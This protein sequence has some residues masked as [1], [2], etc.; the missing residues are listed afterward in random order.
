L[1][2]VGLLA[3][4]APIGLFFATGAMV[5]RDEYLGGAISALVGGAG[6]GALGDGF[7]NVAFQYLFATLAGLLVLAVIVLPLAAKLM[8]KTPLVRLLQS[9]GS[10]MAA[11]LG[12]SS[13]LAVLPLTYG[14]VSEIAKVDDRASAMVLPLGPLFNVGATVIC[15]VV[16]LLTMARFTGIELTVFQYVLVALVPIFL[17][18]G[19]A[20]FPYPL[21]GIVTAGVAIIGMPAGIMGAFFGVLLADWLVDRVRSAVNVWSDTVGTA[22]IAESFEFK[23]AR[24]VRGEPR[25]R[26]TRTPRKR[27]ERQPRDRRRPDSRAPRDTRPQRRRTDSRGSDRK[28]WESRDGSRSTTRST[29]RD[30]RDTTSPTP[31]TRQEEKSPF[32]MSPKHSLEHE[33]DTTPKA[34]LSN[35]G[36]TK[37]ASGPTR[38][39]RQSSES[40]SGRQHR[41]TERSAPA[42][43]STPSET[44]K[45]EASPK[46]TEVSEPV[47]AQEQEATE[48][49]RLSPE[50]IARELKKV[51]TQL[52]TYSG[53]EDE[54]NADEEK[55]GDSDETRTDDTMAAHEEPATVEPIA[56]ESESTPEPAVAAHEE[57]P[58][59]P[60]SVEEEK[61]DVE[62][63]P[64]PE[65]PAGP[66]TYGR[67]RARRG[68]VPKS[69]AEPAPEPSA[70]EPDEEPVTEPAAEP[71]SSDE[72]PSGQTVASFGRGKRRKPRA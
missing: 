20:G 21:F 3:A 7:M 46:P 42:R 19:R 54:L 17:A 29:S 15:A 4:L 24:A 58:Q 56:P 23:T 8:S 71:E 26:Q 63:E 11:A 13:S 12:P 32:D 55:R 66:I 28:S 72:S 10:G 6:V 48:A 68:P 27:P 36:A 9:A 52:Q 38:Q 41:R 33:V 31:T 14:G 40:G 60:S 45:P 44:P 2:I 59:E 50:T 57:S 30:R 49:G 34:E 67:S 5:A 37:P 62:P 64:E 70:S 53:P 16:A 39:R 43:R 25:E 69:S 22:V 35:N 51:S 1:K 18:V 47:V 65:K 61:P